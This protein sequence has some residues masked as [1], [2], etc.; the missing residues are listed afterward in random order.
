MFCINDA[1]F[2]LKKTQ[3][4]QKP[5]AGPLCI[6]GVRRYSWIEDCPEIV[7]VSCS[8]GEE[9]SEGCR[10]ELRCG[11]SAW[12]IGVIKTLPD[13][14]VN[15][16]VMSKNYYS[17]KMEHLNIDSVYS[18]DNVESVG[19]V[20]Y[21][22]KCCHIVRQYFLSKITWQWQWK[23]FNVYRQRCLVEATRG[24]IHCLVNGQSFSCHHIS[25]HFTSHSCWQTFSLT[26]LRIVVMRASNEGSQKFHNHGEGP[27]LRASGWKCLQALSHLR[28]Y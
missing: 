21:L 3:C 22:S 23:V 20:S 12:P 25:H 17:N 8:G 27:I 10:A 13:M 1:A 9:E 7:S 4:F 26:F 19:H 2:R 15:K 5:L 28:N 6:C 16:D 18:T 11:G 24:P 14:N